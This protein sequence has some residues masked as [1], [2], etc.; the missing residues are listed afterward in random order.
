MAYEESG[1]KDLDQIRR[2][3]NEISD[4]SNYTLDANVDGSEKNPNEE[5][6]PESSKNRFKKAFESLSEFFVAQTVPPYSPSR[7]NLGQFRERKF[8]QMLD[9]HA[10]VALTNT[11]LNAS[12]IS[13]PDSRSPVVNDGSN[14]ALQ[15]LIQQKQK[16]ESDALQSRLVSACS[17]GDLVAIKT[18]W[19]NSDPKPNLNDSS[20]TKPDSQEFLPLA[21][22]IHSRNPACVQ[23]LLE[24]GASPNARDSSG[25]PAWH[26]ILRHSDTVLGKLMFDAGADANAINTTTGGNALHGCI[27][28]ATP[29]MIKFLRM[30]GTDPNHKDKYDKSPI[31][32]L[33]SRNSVSAD[34]AIGG[35]ARLEAMNKTLSNANKLR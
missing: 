28:D 19:N 29:E 11:S 13:A 4:N 9:I 1:G 22:A 15:E 32:I 18:I 25:R 17:R 7:I 10:P 31:S 16:S 27:R 23:L 34:Q 30:E 14:Q 12:Q 8:Q 26:A 21:A 24:L 20:F 3:S 35:D 2:R 6:T 33:S 5:D